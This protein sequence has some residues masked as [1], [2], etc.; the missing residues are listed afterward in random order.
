MAF[1][2]LVISGVF[3]AVWATAL[4]ESHGFT[5]IVPTLVFL[6]GLAI[7][8]A[9]LAY[10][11]KS[12]PVG[13]AYSV[14]VGIGAALTVVVAVL[15]GNEPLSP[16]KLLFIAG[17]IGC[18]I[19]LKLV[20]SRPAKPPEAPTSLKRSSP[21]WTPAVSKAQRWNWASRLRR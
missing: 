2:I 8:L 14:W 11:M 7:S 4:G 15:R 10:A 1:L 3:E 12:M 5:E 21:W 9:G 17:I 13:V 6:V 16:L 18:V 19:G 20:S